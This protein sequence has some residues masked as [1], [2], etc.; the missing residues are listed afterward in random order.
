TALAAAS[1][2]LAVVSLLVVP[3]LAGPAPV[4]WVVLGAGGFAFGLF[5]A[6]AFS[7]VLH[8]VP[9]RVASSVS[10]LLPT[11]QQLGGTLG[12]ALAGVVY[13]AGAMGWAMVNEAVVFLFAAAATARLRRTPAP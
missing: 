12:V 2:G 5:T 8:R 3:A 10:G 11:A 1:G 7:L 9:P 13:T 6:S 4:L